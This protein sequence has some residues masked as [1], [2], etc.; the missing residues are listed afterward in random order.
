[1]LRHARTMLIDQILAPPGSAPDSQ[2]VRVGICTMYAV[3]FVKIAV[4]ERR[5]NRVTV[6]L[7][8]SCQEFLVVPRS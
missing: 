3:D 8:H 6:I 5:N 2:L 1:V 4:A 7:R